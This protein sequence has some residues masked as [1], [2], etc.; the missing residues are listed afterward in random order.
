M[1]PRFWRRAQ[2]GGTQNQLFLLLKTTVAPASVLPA[3]RRVVHDMDPDQPVYAIQTVAE[4]YASASATRKAT[5][6]F[7]A[8][9]AF[10]ALALA[11]VGIYAVVS[12][13][14]SERTQ[15][16]G[17][18]MAL[19][20]RSRDVMAQFVIEAVALSII[21][22][23]FGVGL[24]IVGSM[25]LAQLGDWPTLIE[26]EAIATAVAFSAAVGVFFGYYPAR[27]A[28]SLDPIIALRHE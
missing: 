19:G 6:L 11:A 13:T 16:I 9:F 7:L 24:G 12:F 3:V 8:I 26:T 18:R 23:L 21:G 5:T 25:A 1:T 22:G 14:V 2:V 17:L 20:A 15:E 27:K 10:F 4:A 28:A